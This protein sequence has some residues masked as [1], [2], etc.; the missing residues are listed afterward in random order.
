MRRSSSDMPSGEF[1]LTLSWFNERL[2]AKDK[3]EAEPPEA[4][5]PSDVGG[6]ADTPDDPDEAYRQER[7][8]LWQEEDLQCVNDVSC[9]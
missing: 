5:S 1:H 2:F 9:M 7:E 3:D 4:G 6:P 8:R